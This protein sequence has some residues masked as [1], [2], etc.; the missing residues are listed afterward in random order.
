MRLRFY[1]GVPLRNRH[2]AVLGSFC[3][4]D[5]APREVSPADLELLAVM[6]EQLMQT[7]EVRRMME[8]GAA[9]APAPASVPAPPPA[10]SPEQSPPGH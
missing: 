10:Q 3:I 8:S 6:A 2:G 4:M 7:V 5:D 9:P 1:A